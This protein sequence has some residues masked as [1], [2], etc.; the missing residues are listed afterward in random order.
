MP[1]VGGGWRSYYI[2]QFELFIGVSLVSISVSFLSKSE[3][4]AF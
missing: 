1:S 4:G 2:V 3:Q